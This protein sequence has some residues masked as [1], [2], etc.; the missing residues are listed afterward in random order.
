MSLLLGLDI[1]T[2]G[3]KALLIDSTGHVIAEAFTEYP[4]LSPAPL[5]AE[6]DPESWW[7]AAIRSIRAVLRTDGISP[8][9]ITGI[10]LTGQ[11]HGLVLLDAHGDVLRPCIMWNDQRTAAQC[12]AY[13]KKIGLTRLLELTGN[14]LLPGFTAPK[15]AWVRENESE[16]AGRIGKILLPKDYIRY[17]LTGQYF[18]E[19]S[20]ASGTLLFDVARRRWSDEMLRVFRVKRS[21]LPE[22][23]ESPVAS[24][25]VSQEAAS[26]TGL[27]AGTLVVGGAGDQ[28]AGAVGV[29]AISEGI[30]SVVIGTSGVVFASCRDFRYE[31]EGRLHAFCHASP[32][33]WHVMGVM[34]AA[35]GSFRWYRDTLGEV[36][37]RRAERQGDDAYDLLT[38]SAA[39]VPA[40][41]AHLFFLPYLSGERTPYPDPNARGVFFGLNLK[42][43]RAHLTRAVLEGVS[44]G[45]RDSL[46]L[47][48]AMRVPVR[49]IRVVGGGARSALWR[50]ILADVFEEPITPST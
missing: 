12:S 37:R 36:E 30:V 42:H 9:Q 23:T 1:S 2:T 13:T 38:R 34:L 10:G 41:A 8:D 21:W 19:V 31:P 40:G 5:W 33:V 16:V 27:R 26:T 46:E 15:V 39:T 32:G 14:P 11:M 3:A 28:A 18:T 50:Q 24:A 20:D 47:I 44:F 49:E 45:L 25:Q 29:G 22:V 6:Q 48:R 43:T 7:R 4:M 35:G 17:R